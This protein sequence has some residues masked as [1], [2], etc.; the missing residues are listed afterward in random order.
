MVQ[1]ISHLF[2]GRHILGPD[3]LK[4]V[5]LLHSRIRFPLFRDKGINSRINLISSGVHDGTD[6]AAC[7]VQVHGERVHCGHADQGLI[8]RQSQ[9]LCS[10]RPDAQ[11]R[12]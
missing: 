9:P 1:G 2:N 5:G 10:G 3:D 8:Q 4:P 11:S 12:K 6:I 7:P